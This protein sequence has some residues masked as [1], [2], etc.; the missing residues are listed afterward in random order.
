MAGQPRLDGRRL[1]GGV[2]VEFAP[3]FLARRHSVVIAKLPNWRR[4]GDEPR[5]GD[6]RLVDRASHVFGRALKD[7]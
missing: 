5:S 4:P 7:R 6:W 2:I 1:V 3:C